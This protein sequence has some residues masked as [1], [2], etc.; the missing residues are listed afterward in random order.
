MTINDFIFINEDFKP[1]RIRKKPDGTYQALSWITGLSQWGV[2]QRVP[3]QQ[4]IGLF[5]EAIGDEPA[6]KLEGGV[7]FLGL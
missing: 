1:I 3:E 7:P 5:P 4:V 2:R 6:S